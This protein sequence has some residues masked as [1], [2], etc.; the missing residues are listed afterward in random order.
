MGGQLLHPAYCIDPFDPVLEHALTSATNE[1]TVGDHLK[2]AS[3]YLNQHALGD[4]IIYAA[5]TT[6]TN[7]HTLRDFVFQLGGSNLSQLKLG[8]CHTIHDTDAFQ[9]CR[10]NHV[11]L[12]HL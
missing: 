9:H 4:Y 6:T 12:Q 2:C 1:H 3:T 8:D 10:S 7:E 11:Q 5:A